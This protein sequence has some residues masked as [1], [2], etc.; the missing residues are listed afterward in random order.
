MLAGLR[1]LLLEPMPRLKN[2]MQ[3]GIYTKKVLE[4]FKKPHN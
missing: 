1:S 4:L 2:N 3:E